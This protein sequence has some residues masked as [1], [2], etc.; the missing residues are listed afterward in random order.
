L[1]VYGVL[2]FWNRLR[3]LIA[4]EAALRGANAAVVGILASALY[5]PVWTGAVA[6]VRDF[7]LALA[8]VLALI[9]WRLPP[10]LVVL[11]LA[12]AGAART[13]LGL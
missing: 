2:P 7:A 12:V 3:G 6:D 4:A 9:V 1:L 11:L 8:G 5:D 10:W 13:M